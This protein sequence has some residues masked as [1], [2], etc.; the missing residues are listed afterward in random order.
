MDNIYH[1]AFG[2]LWLSKACFRLYRQHVALCRWFAKHLFVDEACATKAREY[3]EAPPPVITT[4]SPEKSVTLDINSD[5]DSLMDHTN[6][7]IERLDRLEHLE[8]TSIEELSLRPS[9]GVNVCFSIPY[10]YSNLALSPDLS[11]GPCGDGSASS[12]KM[13]LCEVLCCCRS[14]SIPIRST[15]LEVRQSFYQSLPVKE[16]QVGELVT[17]KTLREADLLTPHQS[18]E[19]LTV[20]D[21]FKDLHYGDPA[22][23]KEA[24][25]VVT[26]EV[27]LRMSRLTWHESPLTFEMDLVYKFLGT[28]AKWSDEIRETVRSGQGKRKVVQPFNVGA[29]SRHLQPKAMRVFLRL[30]PYKLLFVKLPRD[31]TSLPPLPPS[32]VI[33]PIHPSSL[34][35]EE[36][37]HMEVA[38]KFFMERFNMEYDVMK[39][40]SNV[41]STRQSA[42]FPNVARWNE[43]L[44]P[45]FD[46]QVVAKRLRSRVDAK[47]ERDRVE[48]YKE[49]HT[50]ENS[51][52]PILEEKVVEAEKTVK[53]L[54]LKLYTASQEYNH[55]TEMLNDK[56]VV[57]VNLEKKVKHHQ[58]LQHQAERN[59]LTILRKRLRKMLTK[60][61]KMLINKG[62]LNMWEGDERENLLQQLLEFDAAEKVDDEAIEEDSE[63]VLLDDA[64]LEESSLPALENAPASEASANI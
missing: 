44:P 16:I 41:L 13:L 30:Q 31:K 37:A 29:G 51:C 49:L 8:R 21:P 59:L 63:I 33:L 19:S 48:L 27:T 25:A 28:I 32:N 42:D 54:E 34:S 57:V 55:Q 56:I 12:T 5:I 20:K 64:N 39:K 23:V 47:R 58:E 4:S 53:E 38:E 43:P 35:E 17:T 62:V 60:P 15:K 1:Q 52:I 36:H 14:G 18:I 45:I 46:H 40:A 10:F 26:A 61:R 24:I 3:T 50:Q 9:F 6:T 7:I 22:K 2:M 11:R